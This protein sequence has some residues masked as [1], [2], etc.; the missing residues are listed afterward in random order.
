MMLGDSYRGYRK[1]CEGVK[2]G[3]GGGGGYVGKERDCSQIMQLDDQ[4]QNKE[5][6]LQQC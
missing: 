5:T 1:L 2:G 6:F 4:S 3:G